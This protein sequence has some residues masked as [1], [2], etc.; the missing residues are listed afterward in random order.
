MSNKSEQKKTLIIE[1]ARELFIQKGYNATSFSEIVQHAGISKGSIYYHFNNK[2]NLFVSVLEYDTVEW[3][4]EWQAKKQNYSTFR[5]SIVGIAYH[6]L[7]HFNNP[8]LQVSQ[9]FFMSNPDL[10]KDH[11]DKIRQI[12]D[13]PLRFYED[14]FAWGIQEHVIK[15]SSAQ[16]LAIVFNSVI[17]G[18]TVVYNK[19]DSEKFYQL[20]D[21]SIE[22]FFDGLLHDE[23]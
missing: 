4:K 9:E 8:I 23:E 16:D 21:L 5:E 15:H 19:Y 13:A 10:D 18:M 12:L 7:E 6:Y 2:E 14:L 3:E 1:K 22:L 17:G 11:S 20:F